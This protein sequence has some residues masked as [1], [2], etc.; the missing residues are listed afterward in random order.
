M[1]KN[2]IMVRFENLQDPFDNNTQTVKLNVWKFANEL[3]EQ[4]NGK[5]PLAQNVEETFL[6]GTPRPSSSSMRSLIQSDSQAITIE[7]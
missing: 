7:P 6:G 5:S 1:A 2:K 3:F 4:V